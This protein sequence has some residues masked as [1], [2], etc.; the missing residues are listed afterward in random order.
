MEE[1]SQIKLRLLFWE[2][3][4]A[5]RSVSLEAKKLRL[6]LFKTGLGFQ[7]KKPKVG[8]GGEKAMCRGGGPRVQGLV[9]AGVVIN[10]PGPLVS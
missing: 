2:K 6:C 8:V 10:P 1:V 7:E 4:I 9:R 5:F 3:L